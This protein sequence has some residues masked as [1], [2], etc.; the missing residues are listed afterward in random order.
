[1][2]RHRAFTLVEILVVIAI[3]A[4]LIALLLP[5]LQAARGAARRS[6]CA[7]NLRQIGLA[8][9][10]FCDANQG[11]FPLV[12]HGHARTESWVYSLAP[13]L[14]NVNEI[15][16][17]PDDVDRIER[18]SERLTSYAMNGYLR[19]PDV[20]PFGGIQ[21]GF[22]S[23]FDVLRETSRTIMVFEAGF[24]VESNFDHVESPGWFSS[25]SLRRN[26]AIGRAVWS[27]VKSEV[28]VERHR[29]VANYLYADG[30]VDAIAGSEI[31]AWCSR[32]YN[33]ALPR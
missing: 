29:G 7:N 26:D 8:I 22:A 2:A 28:A 3:V 15:R 32:G 24:S 23:R 31:T 1:M 6:R 27:S 5:A 12:A 20:S 33:F 18:R 17:C 10:Q 11:R 19:E 13:Y 25:Y 30:H 14:E 9:H 16:L 21:P 4:V